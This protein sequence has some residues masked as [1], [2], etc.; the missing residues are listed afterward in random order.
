MIVSKSLLALLLIPTLSNS[1]IPTGSLVHQRSNF[2]I[3]AE[4]FEDLDVEDLKR[5]IAKKGE[6]EKE[7]DDIF[8]GFKDFFEEVDDFVDDAFGRRLGNGAAFYGKRKSK[9]YGENDINRSFH[10]VAP[11]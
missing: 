3:Y 6:R 4:E 5:F 11:Y 2:H 7:E 1:F 10:K 8:R 9:F